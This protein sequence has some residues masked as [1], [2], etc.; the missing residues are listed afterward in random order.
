MGQDTSVVEVTVNVVPVAAQPTVGIQ[1]VDV[2]E[3]VV[4]ATALVVTVQ[5]STQLLAVWLVAHDEGEQLPPVQPVA[6]QLPSMQ[7]GPPH[8]SRGQSP[9]QPPRPQ[10][11]PHPK[12]PQ[13]PSQARSPHSPPQPNNTQSIAPQPTHGVGVGT[14]TDPELYVTVGVVKGGGGHGNEMVGC[15]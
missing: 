4:M 10:P 15:G 9:G 7:P 3:V 8:S 14:A 5:Y 11:P 13:P 1:V 12:I 6:P 2:Q